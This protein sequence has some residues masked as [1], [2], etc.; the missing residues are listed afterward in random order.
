MKI[1]RR[2]SVLIEAALA[3]VIAAGLLAGSLFVGR[4]SLAARRAHA[5]ARHAAALS[6]IGVPPD[7]LDSELRDYAARLHAA[8]VAWTLDRYTGSSSAAFYRLAEAVVTASIA[9]PPLVGGGSRIIVE[10]AVV[11]EDRP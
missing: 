11:E 7:V 3:C 9:L 1:A 6:A 5:L 2:G 4:V 8:D 10:R